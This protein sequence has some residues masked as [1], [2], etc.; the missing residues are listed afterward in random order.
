MCDV[1]NCFLGA[2]LTCA[3]LFNNRTRAHFVIYIQQAARKLCVG[4]VQIFAVAHK[5]E[6]ADF[7]LKRGE[8]L[9]SLEA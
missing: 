2:E 6:T 3:V 9:C 4:S 5:G 7:G 8:W 1:R